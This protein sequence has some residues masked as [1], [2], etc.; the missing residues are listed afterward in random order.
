MDYQKQ[1][2]RA[3]LEI[4]AVGFKPKEPLTFKTGIISP[5]YVDNRIFPYHP[6]EWQTAISGFEDLIK[7]NGL[8]FD[9]IAGI[10]TGGIPHSA[11]LGYKL[12]KSSVYVRKESKGHGKG[13]RIEGGDV[14]NKKVLLIE[15]LVTTGS[16]A[17]SGIKALREEGAII[18]DCMV[19]I[20]YG[21]EESRENF[22]KEKIKLY[23]LTSFPIV[24][25]EAVAMNMITE[26]V[27]STVEDWLSDPHG[28]AGRHGFEKK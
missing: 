28:W 15:D 25:Q 12:K 4:G 20:S 8:E 1:I 22:E 6:N 5:V 21:F 19:I 7:E 10:A 26:D 14:E 11:T 24:L 27:K 9:V 16:S 23:T 13:K 2:A 18:E 3:L 17:L